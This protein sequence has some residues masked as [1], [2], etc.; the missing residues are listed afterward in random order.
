MQTSPRQLLLDGAAKHSRIAIRVGIGDEVVFLVLEPELTAKRK[1]GPSNHHTRAS[2]SA[3]VN[4]PDTINRPKV[5]H[6]ALWAAV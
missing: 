1:K 6:V 2:P 4:V 5:L 3:V